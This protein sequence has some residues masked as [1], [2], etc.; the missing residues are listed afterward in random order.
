MSAYAGGYDPRMHRLVLL[1]IGIV[2]VGIAGFALVWFGEGRE[3]Q[4][5][6]ARTLVNLRD[7]EGAGVLARADPSFRKGRTPADLAAYWAWWTK[8][9]GTFVEILGRRELTSATRMLEGAPVAVKRMTVEL[10]FMKGKVMATFE[11]REAEPD[12]LLTHVRFFKPGE[13]LV[14][15]EDDDKA[16]SNALLD[17]VIA[18]YDAADWVGLYALL[19]FRGQTTST[20]AAVREKFAGWRARFGRVT[21][22]SPSL[23]DDLHVEGRLRDDRDVTVERVVTLERHTG[24][25][26]LSLRRADGRWHVDDVV[27]K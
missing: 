11:F 18:R 13:G 2:L 22:L 17:A 15:I 26:V 25:V 24:S 12:P 4:P 10:G 6:V 1:L 14:A 27:L 23:H 8:E 20:P 5:L 21:S 9:M 16:V 3:L 7:G 19:S